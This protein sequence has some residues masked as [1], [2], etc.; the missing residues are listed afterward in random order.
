MCLCVCLGSYVVGQ[1]EGSRMTVCVSV[2][3]GSY[4]MGQVWR[5]GGLVGWLWVF[6]L[7]S[8]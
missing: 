8:F 3:L 1:V 7:L 6:I 5:E 4:V 2:C